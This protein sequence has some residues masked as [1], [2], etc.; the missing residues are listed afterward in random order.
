M[1]G[2]DE[3]ILAHSIIYPE[4]SDVIKIKEGRE[5]RIKNGDLIIYIEEADINT[6]Y[7][8]MDKITYGDREMRLGKSEESFESKEAALDDVKDIIDYIRN[9]RVLFTEDK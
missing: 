7:W 6:W 9:S 2:S 8:R 5:V 1:R 3:T 4:T